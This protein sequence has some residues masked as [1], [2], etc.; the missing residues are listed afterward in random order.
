MDEYKHWAAWSERSNF[1]KIHDVFSIGCQRSSFINSNF[2]SLILFIELKWSLSFPGSLLVFL[3]SGA[4]PRF[5]RVSLRLKRVTYSLV[6]VENRC[7]HFGGE[8]PEL[9]VTFL[10]YNLFVF[11]QDLRTLGALWVHCA[12]S[13]LPCCPVSRWGSCWTGDSWAAK[14]ASG[15]LGGSVSWV[16]NSWFQLRSWSQGCGPLVRLCA[17]SMDPA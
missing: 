6:P 12:T 16:S 4:S 8:C 7:L 5:R 10:S 3:A 17:E 14:Y 2:V 15:H 11:C 13:E 1:C 9:S